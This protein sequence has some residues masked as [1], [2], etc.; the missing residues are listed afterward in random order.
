MS[1]F[2]RG[3]KQPA[4]NI[5][6]DDYEFLC[7]YEIEVKYKPSGQFKESPWSAS[8]ISSQCFAMAFG[9]TKEEAIVNIQNTLY[10]FDL[11]ERFKRS[12]PDETFTIPPIRKFNGDQ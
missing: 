4:K 8:C 10:R 11:E 2:G 12:N 1:L 6:P 7:E 5:V 3:W 9:R